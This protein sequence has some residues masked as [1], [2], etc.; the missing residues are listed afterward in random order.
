[1]PTETKGFYEFGDFRLDISQQVLLR[2][3]KPVPVTP[4]V[5]STLKLLVENSGRLLEKDEMMQLIWHDTIVEEGNLTA[6]IKTLRKALGDDAANP[7]FI[8]TVPRRG[9]RFVAEVVRPS[10]GNGSNGVSMFRSEPGMSEPRRS[11]AWPRV[12]VGAVVFSLV[13]AVML[14]VYRVVPTSADQATTPVLISPFA[15]EQL[16]MNGKVGNALITPDGRH[17][18]YTYGNEGTQSIWLRDLETSN[19]VEIIRPSDDQYVGLAVSPDAKSLYFVRRP[20][21][22]TV[23]DVYRVSIFGGI[24][25]KIVSDTE[26][27]ISI[28]PDGGKIS[29][30]RCPQTDE[31]Y[32]SLW[33]ADSSTGND[34]R[35]LMSRPAPIRIGP[36]H[37]SRDGKSIV[38]A[39]GQSQN[40][41]TEFGLTQID[42][43][44]GTERELTTE[45]FFNIKSLAWLPDATGLL[46]TASR[47]PA[48]HYRIWEVSLSTGQ[49]QPLT[50]DS[51][52]Y[53]RLSLNDKGDIL[54]STHVKQD[55]QLFVLNE[56]GRAEIRPLADASQ[57]AFAA[58][59][60]IYFS[61]VMS[62]ND[63][64]WSM[65]SDG[66][67][68]RQLT[69]DPAT[70]VGPPLSI[71][72]YVFF[73][74]NRTG[75]AQIWRMNTDGTDQVQLTQK[76]GGLPLSVSK[77]GK[78][79]FYR[80]GLR[81]TLWRVATSGANEE[82]A[83]DKRLDE[84]AVS[85]DGS[86]VAYFE[87][88]GNSKILEIASLAD[89]SVVR[90]IEIQDQTPAFNKVA[91]K[92]DG[93][94]VVYALSA[95]GRAK[96]LWQQPVD[97]GSAIRIADLGIDMINSL[98]VGPDGKSFAIVQGGWK[99]DAV[100]I[101][102]LR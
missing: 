78:W 7:R 44:T 62:G 53:G 71:G 51:E 45:K 92:P 80:H 82:I 74:S 55:F 29:F 48:R 31:E 95:D 63:E 42:I 89:G 20:K 61:S 60:R 37:F 84:V 93:K 98:S 58:N 8:E 19:N 50:T 59:G 72:D 100:L 91:W 36:N 4:K 88:R 17:V 30:V 21:T 49:A 47:V 33:M 68:R 34:Q 102:G 39:L 83:F 26:G 54:I 70:D 56:K 87:R 15:S 23:R 11:A 85:P 5:F 77:D 57:A 14:S 99:H 24:P 16:T 12:L 27:D 69:N 81:R 10:N 101:R 35:K 41:A 76:E 75:S 66:G 94:S 13:A 38:I 6:N 22:G 86:R 32:C 25:T 73:A 46:I 43:D 1:M 65:N 96:T 52:S 67:D 97:R 9:Y 2:E 40:G 3:G 79:V 64:I 18:I 28:S 90:T